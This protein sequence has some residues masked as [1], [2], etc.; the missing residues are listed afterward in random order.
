MERLL[1]L[2]DAAMLY[3]RMRRDALLIF[4]I[5]QKYTMEA[6][7]ELLRSEGEPPLYRN[8]DT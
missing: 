8:D 1:R 5:Q 4:A 2:A 3:P 6:A 7:N